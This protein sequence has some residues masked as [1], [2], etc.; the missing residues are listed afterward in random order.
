MGNLIR[1]SLLVVRMLK[2]LSGHAFSMDTAGHE[3][4]TF[5]PQYTYDFS[6]Q[7]LV[8]YFDC[9]FAIGAVT[10]R[11]GSILDV[12]SR[13]FAQSLDVSEKWFIS[14]GPHSFDHEFRG[15]RILTDCNTDCYP[16]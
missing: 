2:K 4:M 11:Y 5:I 1:V 16:C 8:Q 13:A 12:L 3:I 6:R 15:A 14:H 10:L 9:C 7:R